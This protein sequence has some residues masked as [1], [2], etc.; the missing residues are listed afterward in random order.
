MKLWQVMI[1]S[2]LLFTGVVAMAGRQGPPSHVAEGSVYE[3]L[4]KAPEKYRAK[5]N[6]MAN[7]TDAVAAGGVLFEEHCEE[8][9]GKEALGGRKAPSLRAKEVQ[10]AAPGAIFWILTNGVVRK[11]M[12]VWSKL[13]EP[14][15]WQ[16][17]SYIKSLGRDAA[18]GNAAGNP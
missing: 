6:P 1:V 7:D 10:D 11:K 14:E 18:E 13:P 15:R 2:V 3:E 16:L 17:V 12:P 8:C 4:K 9:H 5:T